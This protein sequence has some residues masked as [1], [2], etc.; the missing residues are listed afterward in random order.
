MTCTECTKPCPE[1]GV[2]FCSTCHKH[3]GE[4]GFGDCQKKATHRLDFGAEVRQF[5]HKHAT[6]PQWQFARTG[7]EIELRSAWVK[8]ENAHRALIKTSLPQIQE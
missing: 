7:A 4:C 2:T 6:A 8:R 1:H 3:P 5:C